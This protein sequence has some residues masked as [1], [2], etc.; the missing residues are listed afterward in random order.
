MVRYFISTLILLSIC[1]IGNDEFLMSKNRRVGYK[2]TL[3]QGDSNLYNNLKI[4]LISGF[5]TK[6]AVNNLLAKA[7]NHYKDPNERMTN[8]LKRFMKTPF[9]Y[10]EKTGYKIKRNEIL[11][12]LASFDCIT[13]IYYMSALN[14]SHNFKEFVLNVGRIRYKNFESQE[15][16][17]HHDKGNLFDFAY[18]ALI[19]NGTKN[20]NFYRNITNELIRNNNLKAKNETRILQRKKAETSVGKHITR[21]KY[22]EDGKSQKVSMKF[23]DPQDIDKIW[24]DVKSGDIVLFGKRLRTKEEILRGEVD[25]LVGHCGLIV[26]AKDLPETIKTL[27]GIDNNS[28]EVY[29]V[30]ASEN[31]NRNGKKSGLDFAGQYYEII[32]DGFHQYDS[33][34]PRTLKNYVLGTGFSGVVILRPQNVN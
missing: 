22:A 17:S 15:I 28:K 32:P 26:K 7:H 3:S 6:S 27:N 14:I 23:I 13:L 30:H 9:A 4:L 1:F 21:P 20:R 11:V 16:D 2:K 24:R 25:I 29:F 5:W 31:N 12:N 10:E 19:I 34:Y 18:N 33:R 8:I